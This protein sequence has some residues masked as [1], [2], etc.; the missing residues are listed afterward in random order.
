MSSATE[1]S[2]GSSTGDAVKSNL[3]GVFRFIRSSFLVSLFGFGILQ[4]VLGMFVLQGVVAGMFGIWGATFCLMAVL[5]YVIM[6]MLRR[7]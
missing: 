5:G 1:E 3:L 4:M 2:S 6:Y 7:L